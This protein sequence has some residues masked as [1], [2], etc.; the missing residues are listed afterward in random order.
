MLAWH[1]M[2]ATSKEIFR[3]AVEGVM[4]RGN[5]AVAHSTTPAQ[6]ERNAY[7]VDDE[8][9]DLVCELKSVV[10]G[11]FTWDA[12]SSAATSNV[13]V[14]RRHGAGVVDRAEGAERS[15]TFIEVTS[16]ENVSFCEAFCRV[17]E[18]HIAM[19]TPLPRL[20]LS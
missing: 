12:L 9:V 10:C 1:M 6:S 8:R 3:V 5:G 20:L 15:R 13:R 11:Y 14:L 19:F 7:K 18:C 4:H 17:S 16:Y 2:I